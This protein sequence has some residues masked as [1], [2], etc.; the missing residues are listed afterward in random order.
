MKDSARTSEA[1]LASAP[2]ACECLVTGL[3]CDL[4]L[5]ARPSE[6]ELRTLWASDSEKL[7]ELS[8]EELR[9]VVQ[10]V[11][12][13]QSPVCLPNWPGVG[14]VLAVPLLGLPDD[15]DVAL[16]VHWQKCRALVN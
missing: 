8:A 11:K 10:Q 1:W 6:S 2:G 16:V 9:Q 15:S 3:A 13:G 12:D 4:V 14:S 5:L 7:S